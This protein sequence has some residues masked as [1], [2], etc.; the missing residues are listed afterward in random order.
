[1]SPG[2]R[3]E[4]CTSGP[5]FTLDEKM[6]DLG[7]RLSLSPRTEPLREKLERELVQIVNPR[8]RGKAKARKKPA[9]TTAVVPEG[10]D[11]TVAANGAKTGVAG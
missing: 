10:S 4:M 3:V 9:K 1:M 11:E 2:G 5:G 6:E 7:N 8:P